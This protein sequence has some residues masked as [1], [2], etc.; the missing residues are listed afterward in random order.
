MHGEEEGAIRPA[1]NNVTAPQPGNLPPIIFPNAYRPPQHAASLQTSQLG[2]NAHPAAAHH[3]NGQQVPAYQTQPQ[4]MQ[5]YAQPINNGRAFQLMPLTGTSRPPNSSA[6]PA[7]VT[8]PQANPSRSSNFN[9]NNYSNHRFPSVRSSN[10]VSVAQPSTVTEFLSNIGNNY[11]AMRYAANLR[12]HGMSSAPRVHSTPTMPYTWDH[13]HGMYRQ[14]PV[15]FPLPF[16]PPPLPPPP[17]PQTMPTQQQ[18]RELLGAQRPPGSATNAPSLSHRSTPPSPFLDSVPLSSAPSVPEPQVVPQQQEA[19]LESTDHRPDVAAPPAP[20][21][22]LSDFTPD[23]AGDLLPDMFTAVAADLLPQNL[24]EGDFPNFNEPGFLANMPFDFPEATTVLDDSHIEVAEHIRHQQVQYTQHAQQKFMESIRNLPIPME[25]QREIDAGAGAGAGAGGG[26][27]AQQF[28]VGVP[29]ADAPL[30]TAS[31]LVTDEEAKA[32]EERQ[33]QLIKERERLRREQNTENKRKQ[34]QL[35]REVEEAER[36][37]LMQE[38]EKVENEIQ[39]LKL[40]NA[41]LILSIIKGVRVRVVR[42]AMLQVFKN[43]NCPTGSAEEKQQQQQQ[44][45]LETA[46]EE[47]STGIDGM[48]DG[49]HD[50]AAQQNVNQVTNPLGI[51]APAAEETR[52]QVHRPASPPPTVP[53]PSPPHQQLSDS[54][55]LDTF[56]IA[57]SLAHTDVDA[58]LSYTRQFLIDIKLSVEEALDDNLPLELVESIENSIHKGRA[59]YKRVLEE[60]KRV[61]YS[62][63]CHLSENAI[64]VAAK[65][66]EAAE[67]LMERGV[68]NAKLIYL[69]EALKEFKATDKVA[70]ESLI[71]SKGRVHRLIDAVDAAAAL[72]TSVGSGGGVSHKLSAFNNVKVNDCVQNWERFSSTRMNLIVEAEEKFFEV[73]FDVYFVQFLWRSSKV[74]FQL[75]LALGNSNFNL[76]YFFSIILQIMGAFNYALVI[77]ISA[78]HFPNWGKVIEEV[79]AI[80][81]QRNLPA[82]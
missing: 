7:P 48:D 71:N 69:F 59:V 45:G 19:A 17:P 35:K 34:R 32:E 12:T 37:A 80:G 61:Y 64:A 68:S 33:M 23:P 53:T 49:I 66:K 27:G 24:L 15:Q 31:G 72:F 63:V 30:A 54:L 10:G 13:Q 16:P 11:N 79:V 18:L 65:S 62:H 20:L 60:N 56:E 43:L 42:E 38:L 39:D 2:V 74:T 36:N 47:R 29:V 76:F 70:R 73:R 14:H 6:V 26:A 78:P 82:V 40:D 9:G 4:Q 3:F 25:I 8:A 46:P 52:E 5:F 81:Q 41:R 28:S 75:P 50:N 55:H 77:S 22:P 51:T 58:C 21:P 57:G 67:V 44:Q 1:G